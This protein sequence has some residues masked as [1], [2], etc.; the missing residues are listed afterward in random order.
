MFRVHFHWITTTPT[1]IILSLAENFNFIFAQFEAF[2][3][4]FKVDLHFKLDVESGAQFVQASDE[5]M[6]DVVYQQ[7]TYHY[8]TYVL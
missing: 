3:H 2:C 1:I 8:Y 4:Y 6:L 5:E 7:L